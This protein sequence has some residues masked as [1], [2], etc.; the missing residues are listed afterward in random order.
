VRRVNG[1]IL[2]STFDD[3]SICGL[4]W[5]FSEKDVRLEKRRGSKR[6]LWILEGS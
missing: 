1:T 3:K 5:I 4:V 2:R 6:Q